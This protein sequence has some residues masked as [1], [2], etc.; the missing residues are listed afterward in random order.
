MLG[1]LL[2]NFGDVAALACIFY[3]KASKLSLNLGAFAFRSKIPRD[4]YDRN[5]GPH[6]NQTGGKAGFEFFHRM[7]GRST[8][9]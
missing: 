1:P 5:V 4:S 7:L 8:K 9:N 2:P 3:L 6:S